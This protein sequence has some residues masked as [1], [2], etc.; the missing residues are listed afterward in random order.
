MEV[1][2]VPK[3]RRFGFAVYAMVSG[4]YSYMILYIMARFTGNIRPEFKSGVGIHTGNW[5]LP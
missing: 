1:P 2:Y 3:R 4:A 5:E